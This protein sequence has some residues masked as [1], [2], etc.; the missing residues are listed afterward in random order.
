MFQAGCSC[1][2]DFRFR[3]S[4]FTLYFYLAKRDGRLQFFHLAKAI[5]SAATETGSVRQIDLVWVVSHLAPTPGPRKFLSSK[6]KESVWSQRVCS[7]PTKSI[8]LQVFLSSPAPVS[9][10]GSILSSS[11]KEKSPCLNSLLLTAF[12]PVLAPGIVVIF[13]FFKMY[14]F[15]FFKFL[16]VLGLRCCAQAF[17]SCGKRGLL[18][19]AVCGLL[20]VVASL[21]AEH[22]L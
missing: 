13:F 18:F 16:A 20:I 21:I 10:L 9:S 1:P 12:T 7:L 15:V 6:N 11:Q 4:S 3:V 8:F 5:F 14:L 22:G 2:H 19:V 17:S